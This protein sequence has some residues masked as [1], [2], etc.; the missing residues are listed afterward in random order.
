[1]GPGW[2]I[3]VLVLAAASIVPL[4]LA[5]RGPPA[6][7]PPQTREAGARCC[8]T[9]QLGRDGGCQGSAL[10]CPEGLQWVGSTPRHCHVPPRRVAFS[11]GPLRLGLVDWE[12]Q[13][14]LPAHQITVR[15]F[16]LDVAE[17]TYSR[18]QACQASGACVR[19][20]WSEP[21]LPVHGVS[22]TEARSFCKFVRGRL[23]RSEEWLFAAAGL[24]ARRFP[25]GQSGLVCRRAHFGCVQGPCTTGASGPELAGLHP[26]GASPEGLLDLAGNVAELTLEPDGSLVAR[27]G[28]YRSRLAGELKTWASEPWRDRD[29]HLGFRCAYDAR[30]RLGR[31]APVR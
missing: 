22:A 3:V 24:E 29:P 1:M 28:S 8:P 21:G 23:P 10:A 7:C 17:V 25:W 12:G 16:E 30:P 11:G 13:D 15:P 19:L 9:G 18:W 6:R 14:R 4:A 26:S 31:S 27:G 5:E 20:Q 2:A